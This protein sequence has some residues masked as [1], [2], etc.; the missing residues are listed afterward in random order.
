V[1]GPIDIGASKLGFERAHSED[2]VQEITR[3]QLLR[4]LN[5][6]RVVAF[7]GSGISRAYGYGTWT[8]FAIE[9][10]TQAK[11]VLERTDPDHDALR[12][13]SSFLDRADPNRAAKSASLSGDIGWVERLL[14]VLNEC[15]EALGDKDVIPAIVERFQQRPSPARPSSFEQDELDPLGAILLQ[16]GIRRFVTTNYDFEIERAFVNHLGSPPGPLFLDEQR[17]VL[18]SSPTPQA[19]AAGSPLVVGPVA[20][21]LSIEPIDPEALIQFAMG[22]PGYEQGVFHCHGSARTPGSAIVTERDYQRLYLRSDRRHTSLREA[23][24]LLLSANPVLFVGLGFQETDILRPLRQFVAERRGLDDE[25]PLFALVQR[26]ADR[27]E[28]LGFRKHLHL[29]YGV[30]VLYYDVDSAAGAPS[31]VDRTRAFCK[32]VTRIARARDEWWSRWQEKPPIRAP[33]FATTTRNS[34]GATMIHHRQTEPQIVFDNRREGDELIARLR[35]RKRG[36]SGLLV[37]YGEPGSG[38]GTLGQQ[39]AEAKLDQEALGFRKRFF[40][41]T[42]FTNDFLSVLDAAERFFVDGPPRPVEHLPLE[43]LAEAL[44]DPSHLLII[45]GAERLFAP[46]SGVQVRQKVYAANDITGEAEPLIR[47]LPSRER[48]GRPLTPGIRRFLDIARSARGRVVLT[49]TLVPQLEQEITEEELLRLPGLDEGAVVDGLRPHFPDDDDSSTIV[50][51]LSE[52]LR[53][54]Y[55]LSVLEADL[56]RATPADNARYAAHLLSEIT[57][58]GPD[59]RA[60]HVLRVAVDCACRGEIDGRRQVLRILQRIALV[61]T[62]ITAAAIA[63]AL[64]DLCIDQIEATLNDLVKRRLILRVVADPADDAPRYTAHTLL[65][66]HLMHLIG[67]HP[68]TPGEL[69]RFLIPTYANEGEDLLPTSADA[70]RI[71]TRAVDTLLDDVES[72]VSPSPIDAG[73]VPVVRSLCRAVFGVIR[74]RWNALSLI[75]LAGVPRESPGLRSHYDA[76]DVRMLRLLNVLRRSAHQ[77]ESGGFEPPSTWFGFQDWREDPASVVTPAG[78]LY[79]DEM[80]W[81]YNELGMVAFCQ[82]VLPDAWAFW[83]T[84]EAI[85]AVAERGGEGRRWRHSRLNLAMLDIE[86]GNLRRATDLLER[87]LSSAENDGDE[88]CSGTARGFLGLIHHL[89]GDDKLAEPYYQDA[90]TL[91]SQ[92]GTRRGTSLFLRLRGDLRRWVGRLDDAEHDLRRS[93]AI[94]EQGRHADLLSFTRLSQASLARR[95]GNREAGL[96]VERILEFARSMGIPKLEADAYKVLADC[97]LAAGDLHRADRL[98]RS[99]IAIAARNDMRLRETA[100]LVL[101]GRVAVAEANLNGARALFEAATRLGRAQGYN[102]QVELAEQELRKLG[103]EVVTEF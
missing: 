31:Q 33:V 13:V 12:L 4:E 45:G 48:I 54:A 98:A 71:A 7:V 9:V 5:T 28:E 63:V 37:V 87:A 72:L 84:G 66:S 67:S 36:T 40:A 62:P 52:V 94:A 93:A 1:L 79:A 97:S 95:R 42:R 21:S 96:G 17:R 6:R 55:A 89:A 59:R 25:R 103:V 100:A 75:A 77:R 80:G 49:T 19:V 35:D 61:T 101:M 43:A 38:K 50:R 86:R 44:G 27:E 82:G 74:G 24:E 53:H 10:A 41:T 58:I 76:Y 81:L 60:E 16:L 18:P 56:A 11:E 39:L 3:Q 23:V 70:H 85:N 57:A 46:V 64:P 26:S 20:R 102:S 2:E 34:G 88:A 30:K 22:A 51:R 68:M 92:T 15:R 91:S 65:R 73:R 99:A 69:Q 90:I 78:I 14:L 47:W 8:Q 32:A 83:Q 29:R